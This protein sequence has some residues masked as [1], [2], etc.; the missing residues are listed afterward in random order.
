MRIGFSQNKNCRHN[1][2]ARLDFIDTTS[3]FNNSQREQIKKMFEVDTKN[4][5]GDFIVRR[6]DSLV[7]PPHYTFIYKKGNYDDNM[8]CFI[9]SGVPNTVSGFVD[10]LEQFLDVFLKREKK[11]YQL[12][13][14]NKDLYNS[15]RN[16]F[17]HVAD[18]KI[19]ELQKFNLNK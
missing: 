5:N 17:S 18:V 16:S 2:G 19:T 14:M 13:E 3:T 1:F 8:S 11:I 6:I 10:K 9:S 4:I 7:T 12:K 15:S